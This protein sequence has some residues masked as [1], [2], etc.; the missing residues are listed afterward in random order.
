MDIKDNII[1]TLVEILSS[2]SIEV[3]AEEIT[4]NPSDNREHGDYASNIAFKKAKSAHMA[5]LDLAAK[6]ASSFK[7]DGVEKVEAVKPGF[8]NFFL[9]ADTLG[10]V[11]NKII[12]LKD[13]YGDLDIGKGTK[14]NLEYI[15]ANPTGTLHLGHARGAAIGD[16]LS[17]LYKKAGYDVTREYYVNDAGNQMDHLAESLMVRYLEEFSDYSH[18]M[19]EDGYHGGEIITLAKKLKEDVGDAYLENPE[20]HL[21]DFKKFGGDMLLKAIKKDLHNFRVDQDVY[22]SEKAIRNR[23]DVDMVLEK[24]KPYCYTLDGALW[25]NTKKDGDDKDRVL[26][27]SDGSYTYLLPD[28]AYHNDKFNRGYDILIDLFGADHHGYITRIKSSQKDLGHNPDNLKVLLIQMVRLF[29]NGEEYKM[30][31]RTGNAISMKELVEECGV[32]SIRYF[33]VSRSASSH[34]DFDIDLANTLGSE[35]PV[36]Y[37]QYTHARLC[38]IISNGQ[39]FFPLDYESSMLSSDSE[40]NLLLMLKDYENVIRAAVGENEPYKVTNYIHSLSQCINEFYS[41]CRVIDDENV[42]LTK[43]RLGLVEACRYVLKNALELIAVS[44]PERM[45]SSDK[46]D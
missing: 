22:T 36:Y 23:G 2:L 12:S 34:L 15:S 7:M 10:Q 5:P 19:P 8:L 44:A 46:K 45:V 26:V 21:E 11:I 4:L 43:Q 27:K 9:K 17:R 6:I 37:A 20:E 41:K 33:F 18:K 24:L 32:D 35:N 16:C 31:K 3:K 39:K 13:H 40:K 1:Q 29:K 28:I 42:T 30:S 38:G 25:L 14:V